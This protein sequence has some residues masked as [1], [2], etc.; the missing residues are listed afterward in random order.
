MKRYCL[1]FFVLFSFFACTEKGKQFSV[2]SSYKKTIYSGDSLSFD[3]SSQ[4]DR[5]PDSVVVLADGKS[6]CFYNTKQCVFQTEGLQ[7]GEKTLTFHVYYKGKKETNLRSIRIL[8]DIVPAK[9]QYEVLA[10]YP[11]DHDAYT[12]GL[13][14]ENGYLYESAG[15]YGE[16][17]L[18]YVDLK[19]GKSI[20][21]KEIDSMYFAEGLTIVGDSLFQL[22][23]RENM[24]FVYNKNTF[25]QIGAFTI[26]TEGWGM[27]YDGKFLIVSDGSE[28]LYFY[29]PKSLTLHHKIAVF[30]NLGAISRL[31][32]LEYVEGFIYA[33]IYTTD[34]II[35]INP[36]NG[37]V[38]TEIDFSGLLPAQ[39][40]EDVDV[41][42]GIAWNP[43]NDH[44]YITGKLWPRLFEVRLFFE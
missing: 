31:N 26:P 11:H 10:S 5:T 15:L 13:Q 22:T 38:A 28:Y 19:T 6:F 37:K 14:Y 29:D 4:K 27:C 32:E 42:N 25:E 16:S 34:K 35:K 12:Q 30:D 18:R 44:F 23:W 21:K 33:N 41:L 7:M 39:Y 3:I 9:L 1:F 8:S 20:R 36:S 2:T 43:T 24:G 40:S 17:S